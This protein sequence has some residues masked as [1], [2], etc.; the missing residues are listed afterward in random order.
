MS[1]GGTPERRA[2][3]GAE[4]RKSSNP[5]SAA[6]N[7]VGEF[8]G[9]QSN[10]STG[11]LGRHSPFY[12]LNAIDRIR[13]ETTLQA[14]VAGKVVMVTGASSGIGEASAKRIAGAGGRVLLVARTEEKLDTLRQEIEGEGGEAHVYPCDLTDTDAI[15]AMATTALAEQDGIDILVN[16]AGRSI[17][18]S[19][20]LSYE[21]F[22]DYE[23]TMQLNYFGAV[24]LILAVLP[25]MQERGEGQIVN[26]SSAGVPTRT[27]RFS[28]YVASKAALDAFTECVSPELSADGIRLT[29]IHM[30]LVRT[31]MIAPT[32]IYRSF[33]ALTPEEAAERVA[34]AIIYKPRRIG[35]PFSEAAMLASAV[36]PATIDAVRS[37]GYQLFPDSTAARGESGADADVSR[38]GSAFARVLRG[39]H[40]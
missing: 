19:V 29:T 8:V 12:F 24:R 18:R 16:N 32:G 9:R 40:W 17:R 6:L 25:R 15:A 14:A 36:S 20:S 2:E 31:P 37:A 3:R 1:A 5:L 26:V 33:P 10:R 34:E 21:R 30:P 13:G 23:R 38:T 4:R 11:I 35:T 22:H 7:E 27:P 28:A 39:I